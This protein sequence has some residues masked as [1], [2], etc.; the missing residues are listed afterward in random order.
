MQVKEFFE[1]GADAK[2]WQAI[3][4]N[5]LTTDSREVK[6]GDAFCAMKGSHFNGFDFIEKAISAGAVIIF[7]DAEDAKSKEVEH[8]INKLEKRHFPHVAIKNLK[9]NLGEYAAKALNYPSKHLRVVGVTGTN[10]KSSICY[11]YA[12]ALTALEGSC[13]LIGTIGNGI[14]PALLPSQLTTAMPTTLQAMLADFVEEGVTDVAMEVS[15]HGLDQHRVAGIRFESAVFTNLSRDHLDYHGTMEDYFCAKQRLFLTYNPKQ[16]IINA[17]D[18]YGKR[19]FNTLPDKSKVLLFSTN[20]TTQVSGYPVALHAQVLSAKQVGFEL[21]VKFDQQTSTFNLP[22][23]GDFNVSN[24]LAVLALLLARGFSLETLAKVMAT[25]PSVPGRMEQVAINAPFKVII[26]YAHTP[27]A[28]S[29]A[30][31]ALRRH[32]DRRLICVFGCGGERDS[33]KRPLM[34]SA[35]EEGADHVIVTADNPRKESQAA[36][37]A[38]IIAGFK[39]QEAVDVVPDRRAAI[40]QAITLAKPGDLI[41]IAGKGHE[42]YQLI[43]DKREAFSDQA[44]AETIL[45]EMR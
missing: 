33:G 2:Q 41:L 37:I 16:L 38:D 23:L 22:L 18:E 6:F 9:S 42:N 24:A 32:T 35:A 20:E 11:L 19:L 3:A 14:F 39:H 43:G 44:V 45:R 4:F 26:D 27:A 40:R 25:L 17:D 30:L 1:T 29:L 7:Y 21:K 13:G 10:G 8:A 36:I 5:R 34:A 15:S 28:L 12:A 31:L